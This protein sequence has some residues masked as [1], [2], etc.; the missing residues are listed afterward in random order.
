MLQ[1]GYQPPP[2]LELRSTAKHRRR[3][4]T[5]IALDA[6]HTVAT[7]KS[8][9]SRNRANNENR[10]DDEG[11]LIFVTASP[12]SSKKIVCQWT[13]VQPEVA[14]YHGHISASACLSS[15]CPH[16][17]ALKDDGLKQ[18]SKA[19]VTWAVKGGTGDSQR[20]QSLSLSSVTM[21]A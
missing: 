19:R 16:M 12:M 21:Y 3:V 14:R 18:R 5:S 13:H 15:E 11:G 20:E 1:K 7:Y 10:R 8:L 4:E 9:R 17:R 2:P 6:R